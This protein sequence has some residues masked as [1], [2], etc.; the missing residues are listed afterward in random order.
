M[1]LFILYIISCTKSLLFSLGLKILKYFKV[2]SHVHMCV[3]YVHVCVAKE[4]SSIIFS[5]L[6]LR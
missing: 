6:I 4:V 5:L 3:L 2:I 1:K